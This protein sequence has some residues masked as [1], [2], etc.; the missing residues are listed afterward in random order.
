M[1]RGLEELGSKVYG[2]RSSD[3]GPRRSRWWIVATIVAGIA[4]SAILVTLFGKGTYTVT[5]LRVELSARPALQGSTQLSVRP[6]ATEGIRRVEPGFAEAGTHQSPM[7]FRMTVVGAGAGSTLRDPTLL[8]DP[9]RL[10][11]F[12]RTE[13]SEAIGSFGRKL[14]L[15]AFLGGALGGLAVSMGRWRRMLGGALAGIVAL[16]LAGLL[17]HQTYDLS[18]FQKVQFQRTESAAPAP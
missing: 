10:A 12:I 14:G 16:G 5:P 15:L 8:Q 3:S 1:Y 13:G 9:F 18:E 7:L 11:T 4:G 6:E 2:R 17:L